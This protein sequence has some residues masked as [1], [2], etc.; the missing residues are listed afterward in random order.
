MSRH[1]P[2][3][4]G[5][6][7]LGILRSMPAQ[8]YAGILAVEYRGERHLLGRTS[9]SYAIWDV[10]AGGEP[11]QTFRLTDEGWSQAWLA[12]RELEGGPVQ[13]A[14]GLPEGAGLPP[15][16]LGGIL[17]GSF[18]LYGRSFPALAAVIAIVTVPWSLL[19]VAI[20]QAVLNP[21]QEL[22]FPGQVPSSKLD[23]YFRSVKEDLALMVIVGILL[24]VLSLFVNGFV[25][26]ALYRGGLQAY[27]G[28][29]LGIGE[30]LRQG[31]S[32]LLSMAW[33][34]LLTAL[35]V[36]GPLL[37]VIVLLALLATTGSAVLIPL[38]IALLL[39][40]LLLG[41]RFLFG[42]PVLIA[43]GRRGS[44]ALRRSWRLARGRTWPILG[45]FLLVLL[46]VGVTNL[47]IT[48]PFTLVRGSVGSI[49]VL[50]SIV[51]VAASLITLPFVTLATLHLYVDARARKEPL[52]LTT[53]EAEVPPDGA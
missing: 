18:R 24:A 20:L 13:R 30:L 36:L 50:S 38:L 27:L 37:P 35:A 34:I 32:V 25:T 7:R 4:P 2:G 23:D 14:A 31:L 1:A 49:W 10:V 6:E 5:D 40:V 33:I 46:M 11:V 43:E 12:F 22:F 45:T 48:L 52:D 15:L 51:G 9:D 17:S 28:R 3:F 53:L 44:Y 19:Q 41:T 47:V 26:A 39:G 42:A 8:P 29:A 16:G 21:E